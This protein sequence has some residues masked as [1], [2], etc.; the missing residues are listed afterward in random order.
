MFTTLLL[1]CA[2][3]LTFAVGWAQQSKYPHHHVV[4]A[5]WWFM[6]MFGVV[7]WMILLT[8]DHTEPNAL[9]VAAAIGGF[10]S[11][12]GQN[13]LGA[14][15]SP[16]GDTLFSAF[17]FATGLLAAVMT[18]RQNIWCWPVG[19]VSALIYGFLSLA[20]GTPAVDEMALAAFF[21][22]T[23]FY[24][25]WYWVHYT[26]TLSKTDFWKTA[27]A[28][29]SRGF[30]AVLPVDH[31]E[32]RIKHVSGFDIGFVVL[33][34]LGAG[35]LYGEYLLP[36]D[37][38]APYWVAITVMVMVVGQ[39]LSARKHWFGWVLWVAANVFMALVASYTQ[40]YE[41]VF[42]SVI[43]GF[44]SLYGLSRWYE[45]AMAQQRAK[46]QSEIV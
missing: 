4:P 24:G 33:A 23:Q 8:T 9:E 20:D 42:G 27:Q 36:A 6:T 29:H 28:M 25:W 22:I 45:D 18:I 19:M 11:F 34:I 43:L 41:L 37:N 2:I 35:Y 5:Q 14:L 12:F 17:A 10:L 31:V 40:E 38:K 44:V 15:V 3:A 16:V 30:F 26:A 46:L 13:P 39:V 32:M 21:F 7:S 1:G